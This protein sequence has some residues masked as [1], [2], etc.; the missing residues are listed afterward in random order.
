MEDR[1]HKVFD[2]EDIARIADTYHGWRNKDGK[3]E[4]EAGFCK[5]ADLEEVQSHDFVLTPGRYV[6]AGDILENLTGLDALPATGALLIALP[7]KIQ[8]GSGAPVRVI[9]VLP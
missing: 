1:T 5:S 4:D 7:M 2:P 9:A 8:G 3:Y 6:G